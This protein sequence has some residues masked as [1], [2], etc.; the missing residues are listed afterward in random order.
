MR[1]REVF[2]P[3]SR[4]LLVASVA[5]FSGVTA[6][7][8]DQSDTAQKTATVQQLYKDTSGPITKLVDPQEIIKFNATVKPKPITARVTPDVGGID[9][10]QAMSYVDAEGLPLEWF[11]TSFTPPRTYYKRGSHPKLE[12][13]LKDLL[14]SQLDDMA[15]LEAIHEIRCRVMPGHCI[16]SKKGI[17]DDRGAYAE[18][19]MESG[20]GACNET[21]RAMVSLCQVAGLP[22]RVVFASAPKDAHVICEILVNGK[23]VLVDPSQEY[24]F[25]R[26]DGTPVSILDFKYDADCW[27]EVN[28]VYRQHMVQLAKTKT[29]KLYKYTN[30]RPLD[31]FHQIGYCNDFLR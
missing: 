6:N 26:K 12:A 28:E 20:V 29:V 17:P 8:Q 13:Y 15:K 19:L 24:I 23:W 18:E 4:M 11:Y 27:E 31:L 9:L 22:G 16:K 10:V 14:D 21:A 30:L 1:I 2:G 5:L 25:R 7:G 3:T